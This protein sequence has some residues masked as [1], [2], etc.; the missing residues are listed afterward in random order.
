[1]TPIEIKDELTDIPMSRQ[2]RYLKRR[3]RD[4]DLCHWSGCHNQGEM[5]GGKRRFYCWV[6]REQWNSY[7]KL[8]RAK[9]KL[10]KV[11]NDVKQG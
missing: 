2:Q 6:H 7:H 5:R 10:A 8:F 11:V 4:P 9:V 1:M 3:Y